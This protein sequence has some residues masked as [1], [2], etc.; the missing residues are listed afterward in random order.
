L[1]H[2]CM[3]CPEF[4]QQAVPDDNHAM[5]CQ[6]RNCSQK[7]TTVYVPYMGQL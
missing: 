1:P 5:S 6:A 4:L 3:F 2:V 7:G